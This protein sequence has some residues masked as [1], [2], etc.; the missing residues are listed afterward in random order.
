MK[1]IPDRKPKEPILPVFC[2][3]TVLLMLIIYAAK[4]GIFDTF[5]DEIFERLR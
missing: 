2:I 3:M 4:V 1:I 5:L